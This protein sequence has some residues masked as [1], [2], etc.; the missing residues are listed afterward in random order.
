MSEVSRLKKAKAFAW[1][2]YYEALQEAHT[3]NVA[4]YNTTTAVIEIPE[5]PKH[6][7]DEYNALLVELHKTIECPICF[8]IIDELKITGCGHKYCNGCFDRISECA[9]CRRKIKKR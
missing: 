5:L 4:H 9:I 7:V 6:L 3:N 2:K 1:A 8:E